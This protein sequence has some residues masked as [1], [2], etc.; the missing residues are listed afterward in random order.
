M[1]LEL[2]VASWSL[3]C[4]VVQAITGIITLAVAG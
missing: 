2:K 4:A 3:A 1:S